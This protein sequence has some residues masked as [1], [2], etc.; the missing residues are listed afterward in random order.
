MLKF[1]IVVPIYKVESYLVQCIESVLNQSYSNFEL[2]LVDDGSPDKC[3]QICDEYAA[4]DSRI[5]VVHK[6]NGGLPAARNSGLSIATGDYFMSLDGDDFW[7][8]NYLQLIS[9]AIG[10]D[11]YDVYLG[12]SRYDYINGK[13][14]QAVLY[15]ISDLK[16]KN[17][18]E[19]IQ[20]F[21]SGVQQMPAAVW[22][23]TYKIEFIKKENL[24]FNEKLTWSEDT[25]F[26]YKVLSCA[27]QFGFFDYTFY[28]YRRD[29]S[30]AM[31]KC[32]TA[33]NLLS[34]MSV[35]K[36]WFYEI[37][38]TSLSLDVK[39]IFKHRMAN[40]FVYNLTQI[41][42]LSDD[43]YQIVKDYLNGC[44]EL[45]KYISGLHLKMIFLFA[46]TFGYR[47]IGRLINCIKR[48]RL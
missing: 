4:Q 44:S 39:E 7:D 43:D 16:G 20:Y 25:D 5:K 41:A 37:D 48:I 26:F 47:N 31:T 28:Y 2:I 38:R 18:S 9:D 3:P 15:N 17:Q 11:L 19:I 30:N 12:N 22:H 24:R 23:N 6:T 14:Q 1:S 46:Q 42:G 8:I 40:A 35:N 45:W 29:N 13:A 27:K 34:N 21:M 36:D 10:D 33:K 32:V